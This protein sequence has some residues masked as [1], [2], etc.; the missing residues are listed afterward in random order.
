MTEEELEQLVI[1]RQEV[2]QKLKTLSTEVSLLKAE[3]ELIDQK[4]NGRK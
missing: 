4:L 1:R 3:L 2:I